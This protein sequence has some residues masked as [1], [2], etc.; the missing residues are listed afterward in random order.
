M[1]VIHLEICGGHV[2]ESVIPNILYITRINKNTNRGFLYVLGFPM[3]ELTNDWLGYYINM[4]SDA[5]N[6]GELPSEGKIIQKPNKKRVYQQIK[7]S[8]DGNNIA[9]VTNELGQY[10][11]YIHNTNTKKTKKI[12][13]KENRIDQITDYSYPI[14]DW[15]PSGKILAFI[16]EEKG[17]L[18]FY[19]YIVDNKELSVRNFLF[20]HKVLDFSYSHDGLKLV[21]SAVYKGQTDIYVHDIVSA[22]NERLT[23]DLADDLNPKFNHNSTQIIFTSNRKYNTIYLTDD[24][25]DNIDE[26]QNIFIYRI[27]PQNDQELKRITK[28]HFTNYR[29]T[30]L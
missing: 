9:W 4:F 13:K 25:A 10:R 27:I 5:E 19:N 20:Y 28:N 14:L 1:Q 24:P 12:L 3:K 21:L 18:K 15:H 23:N 29:K 26:Y 16:T 30:C 6:I 2:G 7:Y 22:T 8:P 11:I 17:M